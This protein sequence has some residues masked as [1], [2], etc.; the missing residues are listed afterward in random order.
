MLT[1]WGRATSVNVQA[2][3]WTVG[4]LGL[5]HRRLDAGGQYGGLDAPDFLAMNPN[6]LVPVLEDGALTLWE[7]A[8]IVRYLAA[9]HGDARFWPTDP[10][11]RARLDMWAEWAR[12]SFYPAFI[13]G[14]FALIVRTPGR[15]PQAVAGAEAQVARLAAIADRHLADRP[16]LG[17]AAPCFADI[18]LGSQLYRY[19]T[20]DCARADTPHLAAYYARLVERPA[21]REHVMVSYESLWVR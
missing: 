10:A 3:M 5:A 15:T 18:M 7:S 4:E 12:A 14:L 16:F 6:G 13:G 17:G 1:I 21:Y 8:A 9:V 19:F 11:E 2:V 20:L